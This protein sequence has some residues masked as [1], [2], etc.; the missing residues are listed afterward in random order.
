MIISESI[1]NTEPSRQLKQNDEVQ[2]TNS[3]NNEL[4]VPTQTPFV[5]CKISK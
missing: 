2:I 5:K 1:E 3:P 4:Y